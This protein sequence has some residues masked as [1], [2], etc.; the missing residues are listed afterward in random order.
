MPAGW[1]NGHCPFKIKR[2]F[3]GDGK[4][5][6]KSMSQNIILIPMNMPR[7][8]MKRFPVNGIVRGRLTTP[9]AI[10]RVEKEKE[11]VPGG[12]NSQ[13]DT[14]D[15]KYHPWRVYGIMERTEMMPV[16]C[17]SKKKG[18]NTKQNHGPVEDMLQEKDMILAIFKV[19]WWWFMVD[20][21]A[22]GRPTIPNTILALM[23]R[24]RGKRDDSWWME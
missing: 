5:R 20:G 15:T 4:L 18:S 19:I 7:R 1:R 11:M 6:K 14:S 10:G 2:W 13:K 22:T 16:W 3:L 23:K 17:N 8:R 9:N 21:M 24:H 12:W